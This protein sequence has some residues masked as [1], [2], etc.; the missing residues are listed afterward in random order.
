MK[1]AVLF[2]LIVG[3]FFQ[4]TNASLDVVRL[5]RSIASQK[6]LTEQREEKSAL[7]A[8]MTANYVYVLDKRFYSEEGAQRI[9][10]ACLN[11]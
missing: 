10:R 8:R 3:V 4:A 5:Q 7:C 1:Q 9:Y 11:E 2:F 6:A